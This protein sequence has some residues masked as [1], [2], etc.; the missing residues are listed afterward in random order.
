MLFLGPKCTKT[1][2]RASLVQKFFSLANA[3]HK[4]RESKGRG[5]G[6]GGEGREEGPICWQQPRAWIGLD[7]AL[8]RIVS[9]RAS[10]S[11]MAQFFN[12]ASNQG[13]SKVDV[14]KIEFRPYNA[15]RTRHFNSASNQGGSEVDVTKIEFRPYNV[16]RTRHFNSAS[17]QGGSE[18]DVTKIEF[19]PYNAIRTRHFNSASNQGGS[20]VDV[21]KIEFRPYNAIRTRQSAIVG[22]IILYE[23][24]LQ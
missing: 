21:T 8:G 16:I 10:F 9:I 20:E 3:R 14:T 4:G 2:L 17:N 22:C 12:S 19:R 1:H 11:F 24:T 7:A 13:G 5:G 15:I 23:Y 6:E 18:V